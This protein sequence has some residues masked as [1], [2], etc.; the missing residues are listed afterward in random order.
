MF[1]NAWVEVVVSQRGTPLLSVKGRRGGPTFFLDD[2][3]PF[4]DIAAAVQEELAR[5]NG[6]FRDTSIVLHLGARAIHRND[7]R[8]MQDALHREG[9]LLHYAVAQD[10]ASRDLLDREGVAVRDALLPPS[11]APRPAAGAEPHEAG[12]AL[13]LRQGL[14]GGQKQVFAGDVILAGDVNQGAEVV[15]GGDV[16]IVGTLRGVVHAGYP[17]NAEAQVIGLKLVPLQL[18]IGPVIAIPEEGAP[19]SDAV[20]PEVARVVDERIVIEPYSRR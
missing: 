5:A 9:L 10:A 20:C 12:G 18:R 4:S 17:D 19:S 6:F 2:Q 7:W 15:A 14:R 1:I 8:T 16:V 11:A 13:Y 3:A